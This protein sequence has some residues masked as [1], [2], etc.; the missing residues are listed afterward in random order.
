MTDREKL[1][2]LKSRAE[3]IENCLLFDPCQRC[4][5]LAFIVSELIG[6]LLAEP[7][8]GEGLECV[9]DGSGWIEACNFRRACPGCNHKGKMK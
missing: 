2:A 9:C 7:S 1:E 5:S 3:Q 8:E 6:V 4:D